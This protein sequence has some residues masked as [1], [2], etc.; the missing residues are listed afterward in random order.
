M[1]YSRF[2]LFEPVRFLADVDDLLNPYMSSAQQPEG[3]LAAGL[4][5]SIRALRAKMEFVL[6]QN[7]AVRFYTCDTPNVKSSA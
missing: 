5:F 4:S 1:N 2:C 7:F 6:A 3:L